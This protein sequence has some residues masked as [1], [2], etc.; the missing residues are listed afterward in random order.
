MIRNRG[1]YVAKKGVTDF[2]KKIQR[3]QRKHK[4]KQKI[5][6]NKITSFPKL[7]IKKKFQTCISDL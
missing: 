4:K 3:K 6:K 7:F 1:C 5:K 2:T